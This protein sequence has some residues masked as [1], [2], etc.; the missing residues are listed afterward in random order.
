MLIL[1]FPVPAAG[2][3][4]RTDEQTWRMGP[5]RPLAGRVTVAGLAGMRS[6]DRAHR[7]CGGLP[8]GA[9][10]GKMAVSCDASWLDGP[11]RRRTRP[12]GSRFSPPLAAGASSRWS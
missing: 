4:I 8:A 7:L 12:A 9:T 6:G 11:G 2:D 5:G 1:E 10:A 3:Q